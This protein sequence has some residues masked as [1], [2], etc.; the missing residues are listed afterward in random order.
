M[1][2]RFYLIF[3][4]ILCLLKSNHSN[5]FEWINYQ[6]ND[7]IFKVS[8]IF[9]LNYPMRMNNIILLK[10]VSVAFPVYDMPIFSLLQ[11][12]GDLL[13]RLLFHSECFP[14]APVTQLALSF[15]LIFQ[16]V[17]KG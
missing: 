12:M 13:T 4:A 6:C 7:N 17:N 10:A 11:K 9:L 1:R 3:L 15:Q 2:F 5:I 8:S 14:S 16:E